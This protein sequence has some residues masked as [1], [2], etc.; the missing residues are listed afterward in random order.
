M[1]NENTSLEADKSAG[2]GKYII[3]VRGDL[4]Q[5]TLTTDYWQALTSNQ[6]S[7]ILTS[8]LIT[9]DLASV[10]RID[11]A[12]L[13]WLLNLVAVLVKN[14]ITFRLENMPAQLL[15]LA[16][17]SNAKSLLTKFT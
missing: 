3:V 7:N 15:N 16:A 1:A 17:L 2:D 12:G 13:A 11:T 6:Q 5:N 9:I 4:L 14:N 10:E 8:T